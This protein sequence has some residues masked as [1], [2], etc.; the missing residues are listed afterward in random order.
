LCVKLRRVF[1]RRRIRD[2]KR[3]KENAK[4]GHEEYRVFI[5]LKHTRGHKIKKN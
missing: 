1:V 3:K 4:M 5:I 2:E